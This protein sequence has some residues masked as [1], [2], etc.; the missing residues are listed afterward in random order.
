VR[1]VLLLFTAL[2]LLVAGCTSQ[3]AAPST[4]G[5]GAASTSQIQTG[6]PSAGVGAEQV[7]PLPAK[8]IVGSWVSTKSMDYSGVPIPATLVLTVNADGNLT[9]TA[10]AELVGE[11]FSAPGKWS[12]TPDGMAFVAQVDTARTNGILAEDGLHW[13]NAVWKRAKPTKAPK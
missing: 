7:K 6:M 3:K 9:L 11:L 12:P 13:N 1:A 2:L 10:Q 4:S 8:D 5:S